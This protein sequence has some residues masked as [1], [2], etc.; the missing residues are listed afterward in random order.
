MM[1]EVPCPNCNTVTKLDV[2]FEIRNF[3]CPSCQTLFNANEEGQ[4]VFQG[5]KLAHRQTFEK[6]LEVGQ[7]GIL[8]GIEYTV[9]GILVK[10]AYGSFYWTEYM[11][12][13][14][15]GNFRYL[16]DSEGHWIFLE[17]VADQYEVSKHPPLLTHDGI[18][19]RLYH[20]TDVAIVGA[21]GFFDFVLPTQN[22]RMTEYIN[23]PYLI[24]IEKINGENT[25]FFGAHINKKE[26]VKGFGMPSAHMKLGTGIVQP[27]FVNLKSLAIVFCCVAILI[28]V[29]HLLIYQERP[30]QTVLDQTFTIS[31]QNNKEF[32]SRPFTLSGGS[33]PL[34]V[35]VQSD[36]DNSWLNVQVAL[37]NEQ[38]NEEIYANKDVEFYHGVEGG[39]S[40]S[41]GDRSE[42]LHICGVPAGKYHLLVTPMWAP[43]NNANNYMMV[44]GVWNEPS[45]WNA[46]FPVL[47]MAGIWAGL[48]FLNWNFEKKR[49][50]ES[51]Y[52]PYE[53]S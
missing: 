28:F 23:P 3:A 30:E 13:D 43:E 27:F 8:K 44:K 47:V 51:D 40:W 33:A 18:R 9:T 19:M 29:S 48:F 36:I 1:M 10:R 34:T 12:Q 7:K 17:E 32:V 46:W 15:A 38:T 14:A 25:T 37:V 31:E 42:T 22:V 35:A 41:E 4:L 26:V 6:G 5:R 50:S 20:Y 24:S 52:S 16:S 45:M 11:L 49:W 21:K 53:E 2:A 39:E